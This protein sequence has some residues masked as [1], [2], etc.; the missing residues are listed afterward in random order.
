VAVAVTLLKLV[1]SAVV[2]VAVATMVLKLVCPA[3]A[4]GVVV[5]GQH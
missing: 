4:A 1:C 3:V 5:K 2:V